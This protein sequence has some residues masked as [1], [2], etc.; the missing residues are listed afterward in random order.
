MK[1]TIRMLWVV[2][3]L[4]II[5]GPSVTYAYNIVEVKEGGTIAGQV[6]FSGH[7]PEPLQFAVEKNP[8]V[9]GDQR[10][11]VKVE[12]QN[13][14]LKGAV[15]LLEGIESGK[16]FTK[17]EFRGSAP[18]KGMFQYVGGETLGL[19]VKTENCNFG[20][21]TGVLTPDEAVRFGNQDSVKHV[22]HTFVSLDTAGSIL[23]TWHNRDIHPEGAFER[24]FDS[25]KLRDSRLVRITCNRHDFMQ[26]WLYVVQNPYFAV[27]DEKGNF[28]IDNIPPGHYTLK[29]WHP[30][31]GLQEQEIQVTSGKTLAIDFAF[32][33]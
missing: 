9:C 15:V 7:P 17:Q 32:S 14:L 29:A 13:G 33:E 19:R 28:S 6:N 20:P 3:S 11:L 5:V 23:R 18:G 24:T 27:S 10:S 25:D 21:F 4:A 31:L 30:M 12:V 2:I 26:N 16:P 22:L 1:H 8:E